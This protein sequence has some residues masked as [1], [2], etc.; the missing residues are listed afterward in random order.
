MPLTLIGGGARSGK[1]A[2]ALSLARESGVRLAF[3]ATAQPAD[4]EMRD[5]IARHQA[6]RG[7]EWSTFDAPFELDRA[8]R[9]CFGFDAVVVD[10]LTLWLSNWM[11]LDREAPVSELLE[12]AASAP[13][14]VILVTNEVG[15]GI[16]PEN[17]LARRFR[18][19]SGRMNRQ[20]AEAAHEVYWMIFG[21]P[22]RLK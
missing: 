21:C 10:C 11:L 9:D 3:L 22:L 2:K 19:E 5:R 17:A 20:A 12:T 8:I 7:P 16:V 4:A 14:R 1:S 18:D 13:N 15:C 6:E